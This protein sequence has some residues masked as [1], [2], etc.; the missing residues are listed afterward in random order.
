MSDKEKRTLETIASILPE[1]PKSKKDYLLGYGDAI[2]DLRKEK[3]D[4]NDG[5][6]ND[7][8]GDTATG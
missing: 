3:G 2:L 8:P 4:G 7:D 1:L 6:T 5:G